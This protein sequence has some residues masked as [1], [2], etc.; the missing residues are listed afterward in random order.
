MRF[1]VLRT[2][3]LQALPARQ[4]GLAARTAVV[5]VGRDIDFAAIGHDSIAVLESDET[6]TDP[7]LSCH[8]DGSAAGKRRC[9]TIGARA[10][11]HGVGGNAN[12]RTVANAQAA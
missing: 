7:A 4:A 11:G 3:A 6:R 1:L 2:L 8:A 12:P 10:I 9:L 5:H